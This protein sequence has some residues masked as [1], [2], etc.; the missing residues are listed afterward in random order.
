MSEL[1]STERTRLRRHADR[2]ATDRAE[3]LAI[4][5]EAPIVQVAIATARGPLVLPMAHGRIG[6]HLYLHGARGNGLLRSIAAGA[7]VCASAT[8]LDGLVVARS[9]MHHSMN[10]R[11]ATIFST[12]QEVED[13]DEKRAALGAVVSHVLAGRGEETRPPSPSELAATLVVRL[14]LAEASVKIRRG[15][16]LDAEDDRALPHYA[17]VVPLTVRAGEP[18][19]DGHVALPPSVE[20]AILAG[21]PHGGRGRAGSVEL[22]GDPLRHDL[23]RVLGWL[24]DES[25]WARGRTRG[26]MVRALAGSIAVGAYEG[27]AQIGFARAVTDRTTFAWLADVFVDRGHRGRGVASAMVGHLVSLPELTGLRRWLLATRDA[28]PLYAR[29]GFVPGDPARLMERLVEPA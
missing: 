21:A 26:Q 10:Y 19:P 17:G 27:G 16:P 25:T 5:D 4:L 28:H 2:T 7:E 8:L 13:Q 15:P 14:S 11:S 12:G 20:R 1:S 29:H 6:E 9:A 23:G 24:R 3:L 22:D 18:I